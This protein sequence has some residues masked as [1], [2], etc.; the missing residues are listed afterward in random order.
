MYVIADVGSNWNDVKDLFD[1]VKQCKNA[2]AD[3]VKFQF[4]NHMDLYGC[5]GHM[6]REFPRGAL[7]DLYSEAQSFKIDLMFT[8]F[9]ARRVSMLNRYVNKW[10][11]AS[12]NLLD[13][14]LLEEL[15]K[16]EKHIY[17]STGAANDFEISQALT[18]LRNAY[19]KIDKKIDVK[20]MVTLLYCVSAYPCRHHD[21][22]MVS[23]IRELTDNDVGVSD[24]S[25]DIFNTAV[26]AKE[27]YGCPVYEKHIRREDIT[28]TPDEKHSLTVDEF[29][30][31]TE[32]LKE[33]MPKVLVPTLEERDMRERW[34]VRLVV[35]KHIEP[36][37]KF[38][39]GENFAIHR[40]MS[41]SEGSYG[42][43]RK[44]IVHGARSR[45]FLSPGDS[46]VRAHLQ[47]RKSDPKRFFSP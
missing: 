16:T 1:M 15:A 39:F 38:V 29:F 28:G 10:K 25:L 42:T 24:H 27:I 26:T 31:M 37:D 14:T 35:T 17:L 43:D 5:D 3:A 22:S 13:F 44:H 23:L 2:G 46:I 18:W 12:S 47:K 8:P 7:P 19:E 34:R 9:S 40:A 32:R 21:L 41:A 36:G 45:G 11:V 4:L 6:E 30:L 20:K 33:G